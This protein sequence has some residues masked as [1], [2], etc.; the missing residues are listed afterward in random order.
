MKIHVDS[1]RMHIQSYD[2]R[3]DLDSVDKSEEEDDV[4]L[5]CQNNH[6]VSF[7]DKRD[8]SLPS[9]PENFCK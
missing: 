7:C 8:Q 9:K 2:D 4:D 6:K 3:P 1:Q 5:I